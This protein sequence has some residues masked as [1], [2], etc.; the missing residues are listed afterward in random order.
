MELK[1]TLEAARKAY[2]ENPTVTRRKLVERL[3]RLYAWRQT[4]AGRNVTTAIRLER[5]KKELG[6]D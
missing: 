4:L 5:W 2:A 1:V 6:E 3:E